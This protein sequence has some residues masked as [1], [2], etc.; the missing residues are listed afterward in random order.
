MPLSIGDK[1]GPVRSQNRI[2]NAERYC[3]IVKALWGAGSGGREQKPYVD[4]ADTSRQRYGQMPS[5]ESL[6]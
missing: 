2:R 3:A 6:R 4:S 5:M 1:L